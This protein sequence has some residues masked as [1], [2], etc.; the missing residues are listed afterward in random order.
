MEPEKL[1]KKKK[2]PIVHEDIIEQPLEEGN[3]VVASVRGSVKVCKIIKVSPVMIHILPIKGYARSK[4]HMVYPSQVVKLSGADAL[5]YILK[6]S[7][8]EE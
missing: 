5:V 3:Y 8:P 1:T 4:G 7:G 6:N 2:E